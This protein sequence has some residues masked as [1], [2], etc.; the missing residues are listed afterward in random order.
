MKEK[1]FFIGSDS[2]GRGEEELGKLLMANFLRQL[3]EAPEKPKALF[4]ANTG[5]KLC[6]QGSKAIDH[7]KKLEESGVEV[8]LCRTCVE[9]FDLEGK[10]AAGKISAMGTL[11]AL[12]GESSI[13]SL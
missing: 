6:A 13:I 10:L 3:G 4:L 11:V 8:L 1:V 9:W 7:I 2:L 12:S 5:V